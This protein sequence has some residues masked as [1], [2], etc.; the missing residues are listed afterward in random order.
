[1]FWGYNNQI[2]ID[3]DFKFDYYISHHSSDKK[4]NHALQ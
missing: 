1:M 3:K 4:S 2:I